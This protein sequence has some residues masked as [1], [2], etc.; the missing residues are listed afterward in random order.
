MLPSVACLYD[1]LAR[2]QQLP[3]PLRQRFLLRGS[4]LTASL[5]PTSLLPTSLLYSVRVPADVDYLVLGDYDPDLVSQLIQQVLIQQVLIQQVLVQSD[6]EPA[7]TLV[8]QQII[9]AQTA[10]PG[11]RAT[12]ATAMID[13]TTDQPITFQVDFSFNDPLSQPPQKRIIGPLQGV[14]TCA[15]EDLWG[16]KLHGLTEFGR[17]KWRGKDLYDLACL[18]TLNLEPAALATAT[19]LAFNSRGQALSDLRDFLA[20]P[21]WGQAISTQRKWRR[22][23]KKSGVEADFLSCREQVRAQVFTFWPKENWVFE[24]EN[25]QD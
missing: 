12:F 16:W 23:L 17:G 3:L 14:L 2:V 21:S 19:K 11:V 7:L 22:F 18:T 6:C 1:W 15:P 5:L 8:N 25:Y 10:F 20:R 13:P 4:L 9:W 24:T